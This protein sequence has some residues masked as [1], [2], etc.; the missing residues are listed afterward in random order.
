MVSRKKLAD[1]IPLEKNERASHLIESHLN[2][3][4]PVSDLPAEMAK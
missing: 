1:F 4:C 2:P 3:G